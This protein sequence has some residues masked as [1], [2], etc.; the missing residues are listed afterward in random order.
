MAHLMD[1]RNS[2]LRLA[3]SV[4]LIGAILAVCLRVPNLHHSSV[5]LMLVLAIVLLARTFGW[6]EA[7][8]AA[9][10][11][12]IGFNYFFLPPNGL[13]TD[14]FE[15]WMD[16]IAFLVTAVVTGQ[17]V[18][19][20]KRRRIEAEKRKADTEKLGGF[21]DAILYGAEFSLTQMADKVVEVFA[22]DG[23]A[24]YDKRTGQIA[25]AGQRTG[26]I[27]SQALRQAASGGLGLVDANAGF[28]LTPIRQGGEVVG[29]IGISGRKLSEPLLGEVVGRI[30][31]GIAKVYA[32]ELEDLRKGRELLTTFVQSMPAAVAMLDREMR[33]VQASGRWCAEFE[34]DRISPLAGR[35]H[36]EL[37]PDLPERWKEFHRR[38]L[39]GETIRADE[40][41][42]ERADGRRA[43]LRWE[44]RP[45]GNRD[46]RPEGILIF[47]ED[48]TPHKE[49]EEL[50]SAVLDAMAHEVRNPLNSVKLAATALLAESA[51]NE[52]NNRELLNIIEEEANRMDRVIDES[53]RLARLDA[54]R[55]SLRKQPQSVAR[56]IP[57]VLEEMSALVG[58]RAIEVR[59]PESLPP[60]E[61]DKD[62][63]LHVL[64]QLLS[65]ALKYSPEGSPLTVSAG[66]TEGS[67]VIEVVDHGPGVPEGERERIFEKHYRGK[68]ARSGTKGT[69]MGLASAR[70]IMQA[71]GGEIW[72]TS[73]PAGGAAF[74]VSLPVAAAHLTV[75]AI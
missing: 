68:A 71:H 43:W 26:A 28:S 66:F 6:L 72:M 19:R 49:A 63:I 23:I 36:Y 50:K 18:A 24:L 32:A 40:D 45:W 42:F 55:L 65:N 61:C 60:A 52:L 14:T 73:P 69:G 39:A 74:H 31:L 1:M 2:I 64:K 7:L 4:A 8:V 30:A 15:H 41:L 35:S 11:G 44:M 22:L 21:T 25:R 54:D 33:Y 38:C 29:S 57:A 34:L 59:V 67:V 48:I 46:G 70:A 51:G 47:S 13:R 17:L 37:F 10:I 5:A 20:S 27:S 58:L 12:G 9:L 75:G 3:I 53:V 56:L 16:F 62:M